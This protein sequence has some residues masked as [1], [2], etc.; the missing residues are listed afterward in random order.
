M[1][2]ELDM[3]AV[4]DEAKKRSELVK[5]LEEI[6]G[7]LGA[8]K[9]QRAPSDDAIIADHIDASHKLA[10]DALT[11]DASKPDGRPSYALE[12]CH[13]DIGLLVA[14]ISKTENESDQASYP[15]DG[16]AGEMGWRQAC[17]RIAGY[18]DTLVKNADT[19]IAKAKAGL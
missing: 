7:H 3:N 11:K 13:Q 16:G 17:V 12:E 4:L 1:A 15:Y 18:V 14:F 5:A 8:A 9:M 6:R 2:E 10:N 19:H